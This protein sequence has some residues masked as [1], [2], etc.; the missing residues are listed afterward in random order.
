MNNMNN[1]MITTSL[2]Q[3]FDKEEFSND[4]WFQFGFN[5]LKEINYSLNN[6]DVIELIYN[7]NIA[8]AKMPDLVN[9]L[10]DIND[11]EIKYNIE[12]I[13]NQIFINF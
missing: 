3:V 7:D 8:F 6:K 9:I 12:V 13:D 2:E 4:K 10:T 5:G 11:N 1:T